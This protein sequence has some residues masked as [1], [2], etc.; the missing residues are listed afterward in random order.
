MKNQRIQR[1]LAAAGFGSRRACEEL[2]L[3][4]RVTVN[5]T[6]VRELPVLV[7][8][9]RD[10]VSVD[11]KAVRAERHVYYLL[12]KPKGVLCTNND[13]SGRVRAVDLMT[14][15]R[16]RVFPVGRLDA[17][18]MGLLLMTNDGSLAQKLTHPRHGVP[19]TYRA[20]IAGVPSPS[21]LEKLRAGVW[22]A[23]GRTA[24]AQVRFVHRQRDH[25]ILEITLREGRNR[26]I[27]RVLARLGHNVRR[28]TRIRIGRLS[29]AGLKLGKF[30]VLTPQ[31]VKYLNSLGGGEVDAD[32]HPR[33]RGDRKFKR[34]RSSSRS[35]G[36]R[37]ANSRPANSRPAGSRST[38][39]RSTAG[40]ASGG[41]QG[42]PTKSSTV[43]KPAPRYPKAS[44]PSP[45]RRRRVL[46]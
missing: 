33:P 42:R 23:E 20:E 22:L 8:P 27:R 29:T 36:S 24:P 19:K 12:N 11:G 39:S 35:A 44:P 43:R 37:P 13:P 15:V 16:E 7:D 1:F 34:G 6:V 38:G 10:R 31:E 32:F 14:G 45:A 40:A 4:G 21:T 5:E 2:V 30:R 9:T 18:S 3:R 17:D 28:L 41:A 46:E 25:C 26:E